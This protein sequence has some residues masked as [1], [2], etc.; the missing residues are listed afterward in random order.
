[1]ITVAMSTVIDADRRR[2]WHAL[3]RPDEIVRWS[4]VLTAGLAIPEAHPRPGQ[5]ARWRG[6]L[7]GVPV[8]VTERPLDVAPAER[9]RSELRLS[10]VR[11]EQTWSL[12]AEPPDTR[13][14]LALKLALPSAIPLVDGLLDRF[15]VRELAQALADDALRAVKAW[16]ERTNGSAGRSC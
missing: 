10:L 12:G 2:V 3:T 7:R 13:T 5:A 14:R 1:M 15:G 8:A 6:L 16:C 4:P 9:L 11:V